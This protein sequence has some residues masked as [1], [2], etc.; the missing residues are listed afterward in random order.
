MGAG[1]R[2][3]RG[4]GSIVAALVAISCSSTATTFGPAGRDGGPPSTVE[5]GSVPA[6][7]D[8]AVSAVGG[9]AAASTV[10]QVDGGVPDSG[11]PP[12]PP[13]ANVVG[14][15][16]EDSVGIDFDPV[17]EAVDYRV[18]PL[19]NPGEVTAN[20]DGSLTIRNAV[21]RCAGVRQT[22]D[23]ENNL[24]AGQAGL[25]LE[26]APWNWKAQVDNNPTLGYVYVAP[27]D[28]RLP[29][30]ALG[31]YPGSN[32]LGWRESRFKR[33]TTDATER[34]T[35]LGQGWRDDGIVFYVPSAS[36]S[37]TVT[38]YGSQTADGWAGQ[39][40]SHYTQYY[41]GPAG[42]SAHMSDTTPPA[43]AFEVLSAPATGT[44]PLSAVLYQ[45]DDQ[46]HTELAVGQ[47]RFQ[48]ALYQGNGPLWHLEWSGITQP[49]TL[50]VE[51]LQS[52][53]P[54]PGLLSPEHFDGQDPNNSR[55][56]WAWRTLGDLQG[57]SATGEVFVNGQ[58]DG[59]PSAPVPIAR[60]FLQV[61]PQPATGW[62]FYENF[63]DPLG[64]AT[65]VPGCLEAGMPGYNCG[66]WT[67]STFDISIYR[68]EQ[69]SGSFVFQYGQALGQ[70]WE[71]FDDVASDVTGKVRFTPLQTGTVSADPS[72]FFH[73]TLSFNMVSTDR[74]YPQFI[75]SDQSPP[76]QEGLNNPNNNT[77]LIQPILGP[78]MR[79]EAQAIHGLVKGTQWD[80]NNQ[81]TSHVFVPSSF[82]DESGG[83]SP[84]SPVEPAFEHSGV[85][86]LTR[87]DAYVSSER[88][89]LFL[90]GTPAGCMLFPSGFALQG[91]VTVTAGDVLYHELAPDAVCS[92]AKPF[93]YLSAHGCPETERHFDDIGYKSGVSAPAWDEAILP[94]VDY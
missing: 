92:G 71:I 37:T 22:Y 10:G 26:N 70:L 28:G 72:Q 63:H 60:S 38:I 20:P 4:V 41:F 59:V 86:R 67:T 56:T 2:W 54:F 34:Q 23:L 24:N 46:G 77:L 14:V 65:E 75:I 15:L 50:V 93:S 40:W 1:K 45:V 58:Y 44:K 18:Y 83:G 66:H 85:D 32:E 29:V 17:D 47:A 7:G 94:C 88:L 57:A 62:D 52:G 69:M 33:Y 80:V 39:S 64:A 68:I 91:A 19:P 12:L 84:P 90:D 76:V 6:G 21:Y 89:Y 51:A 8:G 53:C 55:R 73:A 43:P 49:T 9:D 25:F 3:F 11:L 78:S 5:A 36:G 27:A 48:R 79:I 81:L 16:R 42:V 30:Y 82:Q 31:G 35:L 13:L 74:R 61:A 87:F